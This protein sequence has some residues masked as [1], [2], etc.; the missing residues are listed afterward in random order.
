MRIHIF[1]D[2][3]IKL[4]DNRKTTY[5][6]QK[7]Q[8]Y[9]ATKIET[10]KISKPTF[11]KQNS[12]KS[13]GEQTLKNAFQLTTITDWITYDKKFL[14]TAFSFITCL[15][16]LGNL[17]TI[18]S[19]L[20]GALAFLL[21]FLINGTFLGYAFFEKE[22]TF[23]KLTLG[24][25]LL[26][27]A[28]GILGLLTMIVYNLDVLGSV[29]TL[30]FVAT[31]SSSANRFKSRSRQQGRNNKQ[32]ECHSATPPRLYLGRLIYLFFI[33][34]SLYLL[35]ISRS[36]EVYTVWQVLHTMFLPTIFASTLFLLV[37]VF[38]SE[39]V[40]YKL[41]FVILHSILLHSFM[42]IVF[43]AGNIGAQQETLGVTRLVFDGVISNGIGGSIPYLP[44][45]VYTLLRGDNFQ[46]VFSVVF[47]RMLSIDVYW[48]HLPL[49]PLLWGIFTPLIAF[50]TSK[51]LGLNENISVLCSL[52]VSLFP[53]SIVWGYA[54]IPNGLSYLFFFCFIYFLLKYLQS[55]KAKELFLVVVFLAA[56]TFS[57]FLAGTIALSLL[58]L[59]YSVKTYINEKERSPI[60]AKLTLL[61]SF[62]FCVSI[63]P[64]ALAYR[65][66]FYPPATTFFS[67]NRFREAPLTE[68]VLPFLLGSYF[69]FISRDAIITTLIFGIAPLLGLIGMI[70]ILRFKTKQMSGRAIYLYM[71]FLFLAFLLVVADDRVVKFFMIRVPFVEVDRLWVFRDL[72]ATPFTALLIG[73]GISF[74]QKKL[75]KHSFF[76]FSHS[77]RTINLGSI[78]VSFLAFIILSGWITFSVYYAYP[79]YAPMQTT[80]YE[81]EAVK[82]IDQTT[83]E[84][85]IVVGDQ[86]IIFA[87]QMF[88]GIVNPRAFYFSHVDPRGVSL[89]IKMKSNATNET[90]IE[91]M[92]TN[93]ATIAYFIIE[94]PRLG[95]E[96]YSSII[97]Q[98]QQNNLQTYKIFY[99]PEG[100]EKLRI[101]YYKKSMDS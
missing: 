72:I 79:H 46:T 45:K 56:S 69:D 43:P 49:I 33:L 64:F 71:L 14:P 88:V 35:L 68:M 94:K 5:R 75:S 8:I 10:T 65:R 81:I 53:T 23:L 31:L 61:V 92:K 87:G 89:F 15:A 27:V 60:S 84:R 98:A 52:I 34:L 93:N 50:M 76:A 21:Y 97:N 78:L 86:W 63:L 29:L 57:H 22:K 39:K 66:L 48:T 82:Y 96:T 17:S 38:S 3:P 80:T 1:P 67:L 24:S 12:S 100:E 47:A 90:L 73:E 59:A 19:P 2:V 55:N 25:L 36:G 101:F 58:I 99:Y 20:V 95:T 83:N 37:I 41:L 7:Q 42:V 40:E 74:A 70:Y 54:S 91:A 11:K 16:I 9:T 26:I 32:D 85:Y 62:I 28:L 18:R 6:T 77:K 4:S 30:V 13:L 44:R 51:T